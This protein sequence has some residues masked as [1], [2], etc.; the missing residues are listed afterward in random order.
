MHVPF[1]RNRNVRMFLSTNPCPPR[2]QSGEAFAGICA[3]AP[4]SRSRTIRGPAASFHRQARVVFSERSRRRGRACHIAE[5]G[6][7]AALIERHFI[8]K[9]V[10][11]LRHPPGEALRLPDPREAG[12][13]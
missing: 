3:K 13:R 5:L 6:E 9:A 7:L 4:D 12:A 11:D 8:G 1:P 2:I 10:E